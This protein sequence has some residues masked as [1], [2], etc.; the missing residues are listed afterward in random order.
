VLNLPDYT[1]VRLAWLTLTEANL[2]QSAEPD[3][4]IEGIVPLREGTPIFFLRS[5][6]NVTVWSSAQQRSDAPN[7]IL[8]S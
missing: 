5:S 1:L 6:S 2:E 3:H 4:G 7:S 8:L